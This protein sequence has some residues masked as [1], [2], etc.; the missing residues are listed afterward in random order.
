M[1]SNQ[2]YRCSACSAEMSASAAKCQKCGEWR[3]DIKSDRNKSY[4]WSAVLIIIVIIFF[5]GESKWWWPSKPSTPPQ[6]T[7]H[8]PGWI[9][10][11][12]PP[13]FPSSFSWDTFFGSGSGLLIT[14][15]FI[16]SLAL[17]LKFY[18]SASKKMGNWWWI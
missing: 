1:N 18:V 5:Y 9:S 16:L 17:S 10:E 11:L 15:V 3:K 14:V 4:F 8:N 12:V 13:S 6:I 2:T 7:A